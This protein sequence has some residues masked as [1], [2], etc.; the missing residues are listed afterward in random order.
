M[1]FLSRLFTDTHHKPPAIATILSFQ[2]KSF[3]F[4]TM[5]I[6]SLPEKTISLSK[7]S[8]LLRLCFLLVLF[9]LQVSFQQCLKKNNFIIFPWMNRNFW[10]KDAE[11]S[12]ITG[13]SSHFE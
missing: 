1:C 3:M 9:Y 4:S 6:Q 13:H 7:Q 11:N 2:K 8:K 12:Q 10:E 5:L